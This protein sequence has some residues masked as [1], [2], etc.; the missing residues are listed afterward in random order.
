MCW[1]SKDLWSGNSNRMFFFFLKPDFQISGDC[2]ETSYDL[3][4]LPSALSM[5]ATLLVCDNENKAKKGLRSC[6]SIVLTCV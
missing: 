6:G 4:K 3:F 2:H 1:S 5:I